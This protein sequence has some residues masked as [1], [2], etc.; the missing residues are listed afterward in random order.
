MA[1]PVGAVA[2]AEALAD[3]VTDA[4]GLGTADGLALAD[5]V[6]GVGV[7]GALLRAGELLWEGAGELV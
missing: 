2:E 4:V 7:A 1:V 3:G 6:P 5:E